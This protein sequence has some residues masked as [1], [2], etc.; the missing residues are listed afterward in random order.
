MSE[1]RI[2]HWEKFIEFLSNNLSD[3]DSCKFYFNEISEGLNIPTEKVKLLFRIFISANNTNHAIFENISLDLPND[4]V[5]FVKKK[6]NSTI[7]LKLSDYETISD[8]IYAF[9][10]I[11]KGNPFQF[12]PNSKNPTLKKINDLYG[13][14][15]LS[16]IRHFYSLEE[17]S[18]ELEQELLRNFY[19]NQKCLLT[20][21]QRVAIYLNQFCL[22]KR[23]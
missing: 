9:K 21:Q 12:N 19:K 17:A 4:K 22:M 16:Y 13:Q 20:L 14:Y 7:K 6:D 2:D 10:N 8:L 5:N 11:N 18:K 1:I 15:R 23:T 3:N